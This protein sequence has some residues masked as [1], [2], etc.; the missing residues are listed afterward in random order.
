MR[1][2]RQVFLISNW[3]HKEAVE[4]LRPTGMAL[5]V[6]EQARRKQRIV[7]VSPGDLLVLYTDGITEA[8]NSS[9]EFYGGDRL[10]DVVLSMNGTSASEVY[11][12]LLEDVHRFMGCCKRQDDIALVVIRRQE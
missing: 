12:A 4:P 2:I 9:G 5:G 3:R 11:R 8:Q 10:L 7:R 6:S 1:V